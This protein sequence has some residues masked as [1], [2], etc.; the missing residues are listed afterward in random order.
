MH[1]NT[2]TKESVEE[3]M[4]AEKSEV[5][6]L[7]LF[8]DDV[9]TFDWVIDTLIEVCDHDEIQAEQCAFIVH[10]KGKCVVKTA[11]IETLK[12][13]LSEMLNRMLSAQ[14]C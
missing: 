14:I 6:D 4:L 12:P 9:N 5:F 13:M 1:S 2:K 10:Y 7:V 11:D 3:V 8:N